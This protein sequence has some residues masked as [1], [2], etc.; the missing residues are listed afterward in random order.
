[1]KLEIQKIEEKV[2]DALRKGKGIATGIGIFAAILKENKILLRQRV[3]KE[4][5]I[6]GKDLSGKWELPGGG[7]ELGDFGEDYQSAIK[8]ALA[9]EIRE[10][11]GLEIDI[12]KVPIVLLPAVL[13]KS[14]IEKLSLID[15]AFVVPIDIEFTKVTKE[16]ERKIETGEIRWF[17]INEIDRLEIVSERMKYLISIS[18]AL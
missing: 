13:K 16:Y 6:Y 2:R 14:S 8:N 15:W 7:V 5:L 17:P 11:T 1:V 18:I 4:S 3:E 10:E 9:R 12:E